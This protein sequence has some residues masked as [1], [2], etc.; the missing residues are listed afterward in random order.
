MP[1]ILEPRPPDPAVVLAGRIKALE[2]RVAALEKGYH[3]PIMPGGQTPNNFVS[4]TQTGDG[5]D[6]SLAATG[7]NTPRLWVRING[8]WRYVTLT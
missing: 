6:G 4:G 3:V 7:P 5:Q 2:D 1:T 8:Q